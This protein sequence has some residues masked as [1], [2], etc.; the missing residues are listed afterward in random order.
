MKRKTSWILALAFSAASAT[1][2]AAGES[3]SSILQEGSDSRTPSSSQQVPSSGSTPSGSF[4]ESEAFAAMDADASG[5]I[6]PNEAS[7]AQLD[8]DAVDN[9]GDGNISLDEYSEAMDE[10]RAKSPESE[11]GSAES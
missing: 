7:M 8:V 5:L 3:D 2:F 6:E 9:D 1:A 10:A 11:T 4:T